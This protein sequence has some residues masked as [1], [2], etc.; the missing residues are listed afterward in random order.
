VSRPN[1]VLYNPRSEQMTMPLGL[2]AIGG[3]LDRTTVDVRVVDG[4]LSPAGAVR[5][6]IDEDTL[7]LGVTVLT[8]APIR[9]ALA[10]SRAVRAT[11][12]TLPVVWGG[13]HPS[14]F[15]T[16]T[17]AEPAVDVTVQGQ[18]EETFAD[19]IA[20]LAAGADVAE[21]TADGVAHRDADGA[22]HQHPRRPMRPMDDL[23]PAAYDL[24]DV[25]DYFARK[26]RRQLDYVSST[27]CRF[28]CAF[29]ADP[30]VHARAW[31]GLSAERVGAELA[32]LAERHH[33]EDVNFQD[34][35]FFTSPARVAA[36]AEEFLRRGLD[37]TWAGTLRADQSARIDEEQFALCVRSGLRRVMIGVE[38]GWQPTL[39]RIRKDITVE[40]VLGAADRCRRHGVGAIFPFIVG[41]PDEPDESVAASLALVKRLRAM[42]PDFATPVFFFRPYPGSP[43]TDDA[44]RAGYRLPATLEEWADFDYVYGSS[45]PWVDD[46]TERLVTRFRFYNGL[47]GGPQRWW[48]RPLQ[49]TAAWR[50]RHDEYRL[51]VEKVLVEKVLVTLRDSR[52]VTG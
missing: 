16:E 3:A 17:L 34:E 38:S 40:Q 32:D 2:L 20:Q 15:P 28:R 51:P 42:S 24:V 1:V 30:S 5:A 19:V 8:G 41:F 6:A 23:P 7:C 9:D 13:W 36:I 18:G 26:R 14:L 37:L 4:R 35:T 46:G 39:D 52:A 47:A 44:V 21:L 43:L 10:V 29:C 45:G 12:P 25:E 49:A 48:R 22:P 11:T 33:V 31:S 27:G 50:C